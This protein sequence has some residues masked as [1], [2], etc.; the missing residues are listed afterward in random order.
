MKKDNIT[1]IRKSDGV[2]RVFTRDQW[3]NLVSTNHAGGYRVISG[4][5]SNA[6]PVQISKEIL[7]I[8]E[9][10]DTNVEKTS[11]E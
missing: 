9:E 1:V 8:I 4:N 10:E 2:Q 7:A 3:A 6:K 5:P 11:D